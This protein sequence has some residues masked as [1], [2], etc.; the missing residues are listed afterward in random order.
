[1]VGCSANAVGQEKETDPGRLCRASSKTV[2]S[3]IAQTIRRKTASLEIYKSVDLEFW[4]PA[5]AAVVTQRYS[6]SN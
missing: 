3:C 6:I 2:R 5:D 4:I 1:M